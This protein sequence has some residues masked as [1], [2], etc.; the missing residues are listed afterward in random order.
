L[1][2]GVYAWEEGRDGEGRGEGVVE[3]GGFQ[4]YISGEGEDG[5]GGAEEVGGEEIWRYMQGVSDELIFG[6]RADLLY[7]WFCGYDGG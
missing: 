4:G 1:G 6:L 5:C 3:V 2:G 7:A